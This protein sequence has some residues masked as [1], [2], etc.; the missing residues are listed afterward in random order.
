MDYLQQIKT[1][2]DDRLNWK[3]CTCF[4]IGKTDNFESRCLEHRQEEG[5]TFCWELAKG[6]AEL[7][8]KLEDNLIKLYKEDKR[9]K[10]KNEGS[11]GNPNADTLY[12]AFRYEDENFNPNELHDDVLPIQKGFP[13][14]L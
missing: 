6:E 7:I 10:N 4:Y 11:G 1:A 12:V 2:I 8:S 9:L 3:K 14:Q 5:Y 13:I